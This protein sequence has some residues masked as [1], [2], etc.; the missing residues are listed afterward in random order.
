[1]Q[2]RSPTEQAKR[3][4]SLRNAIFKFIKANPGATANDVYKYVTVPPWSFSRREVK[5][6]VRAMVLMNVIIGYG[7]VTNG[8]QYKVFQFS[9]S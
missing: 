9:D 4:E 7:S 2:Y 8:R 6:M 3:N 1:M 5:E